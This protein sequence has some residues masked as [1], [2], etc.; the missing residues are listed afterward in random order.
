MKDC[1]PGR[2]AIV[3]TW[4][5]NNI[6]PCTTTAECRCVAL[7]QHLIARTQYSAEPT[8]V[9]L[10]FLQVY[11]GCVGQSRAAVDVLSSCLA[12]MSCD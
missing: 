12:L 3:V 4:N 2:S 6:L 10:L 9:L 8:M 5:V 7:N 11:S 1:L